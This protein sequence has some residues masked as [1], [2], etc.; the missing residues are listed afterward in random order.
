LEPEVEIGPLHPVEVSAMAQLLAE[1][2]TLYD[3]PAVAVGL[4]PDELE[5]LIAAFGPKALNEQLSVV[6]RTPGD[7]LL[8]AVLVEDFAT[9]PP[10]GIVE[11]A[12]TFAPIGAMLEDLDLR[13]RA[14]RSIAPGTYAHVFMVGV[15][16]Q[17]GGRGLAHRLIQACLDCARARGYRV[18]VTEATNVVSQHIFRKLGFREVLSTSY[19][20]FIFEGQRVFSSIVGSESTILM[21]REL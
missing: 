14:N 15:A 4:A 21:D 6:A 13:Y 19:R 18:A 7:G 12:P 9:P 1:V 2:F 5:G 10:P 20:D 8:G 3:P 17:A 11:R 16:R